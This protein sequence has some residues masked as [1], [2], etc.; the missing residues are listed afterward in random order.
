MNGSIVGAPCF[1]WLLIKSIH[2]WS[3]TFAH[4]S[5]LFILMGQMNELYIIKQCV[6]EILCIEYLRYTITRG[7]YQL[8]YIE[9]TRDQVSNEKIDFIISQLCYVWHIATVKTQ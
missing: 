1:Y 4:G 5:L 3:C 2:K 9:D 8:W 6:P 7:P